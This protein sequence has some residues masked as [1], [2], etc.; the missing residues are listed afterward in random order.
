MQIQVVCCHPL[1]DSYEHA[2]FRTDV[3]TLD[4]NGHIVTATDH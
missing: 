2:L 4:Q 3:G 1:T